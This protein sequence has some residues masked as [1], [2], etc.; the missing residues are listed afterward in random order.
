MVSQHGWR[1]RKVNWGACQTSMKSTWKASWRSHNASCRAL[2]ISD[3][4][5]LASK[6]DEEL[7]GAVNRL[8]R[9]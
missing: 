7:K 9:P 3:N 2:Q 4:F 1:E 5:T 6:D 8:E